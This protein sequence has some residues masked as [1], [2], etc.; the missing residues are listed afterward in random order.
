MDATR[1]H[2]VEAIFQEIVTQPPEGRAALLEERCGSDMDLRDLV[3]QLLDNDS[4]GMGDF[5]QRPAIAFAESGLDMPVPNRVGSYRVVRQLGQGGMGV[6]YEAEQESPRREVALKLIR[7]GLTSPSSLSRF[8]FEAEIL[9][10]LQHPGIARVFEAGVTDVDTDVGSAPSQ[11]FF[12]MELVRGQP[13]GAH[14]AARSLGIRDRLGLVAEICDAVQYAH[15]KG[16]IHRDLKPGNIIVDETGPKVLDFGVARATNPDLPSATLQT[17]VGQLVGTIAYMSPEQLEATAKEADASSDVYALGVVAYELLTGRLP[18]NVAEQPLP[19]AIRMISEQEA[20]PAGA[21]CEELAGDVEAILGKAMDKSPQRRYASAA[22]FAA[23]IRRYLRNEPVTARAPSA[24][25]LMQRFARRNRGLVAGMAAT[26]LALVIGLSLALYAWGIASRERDEKGKALTAEQE[27]RAEA[28]AVTLFFADMLASADP[29]NE[30]RDARVIDLLDSAA[31][32]VDEEFDDQPIVAATLRHVIGSTYRGLGLYDQ[33]EPH[34]RFALDTRMQELGP[35]A[36]PTLES[37]QELGVL[38]NHWGR[39]SESQTLLEGAMD[40]YMATVGEEHE[41]AIANLHERALLYRRQGRLNLGAELSHRALELRKR[42][43]G[44]EHPETL[45]AM[46]NL[47]VMYKRMGH[48]DEAQ[49]LYENTLSIRRR[50]L[51]EEHPRTLTSMNNLAHLYRVQNRH[52]ESAALHAET[53]ETRRRVLG[54]EHPHTLMSMDNRAML[55][56]DLDRLDEAEPLYEE[57]LALKRSTLGEEHPESL[58]SMNNLAVLYYEQ[59][60]LTESESL[61]RETLHMRRRI[62]GDR[63]NHT[64]TSMTNLAKTLTAMEEYEEAELLHDDALEF[65]REALGEDHPDVIRGLKFLAELKALQ[66]DYE[67][68]AALYYDS[69]AAYQQRFPKVNRITSLHTALAE[70]LRKLGRNDEADRLL[71]PAS[72]KPAA[73]D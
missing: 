15:R 49:E 34:V 73:P 71:E 9:G 21:V 54:N 28:E 67:A 18:F 58:V 51:G 11:P 31:Q 52:E 38:Y 45:S 64:A 16:V 17:G 39:Y 2:R 26:L 37:M 53:L 56:V 63:H 8:R 24:M 5:M 40:G 23:D 55:L 44:D 69:L 36:L 29:E 70:V 50:I 3:T 10:Q 32:S 46:N 30:G 14:A 33:A 6:V 25:Y 35:Q 13:L 60:R 42:Q 41:N 43:L 68:A 59:D 20:K 12:A 72:V 27:A 19:Q 4:C 47:G 22:E 61:Q 7:G 65:R 62:L 48:Y 1:L 66:D 57:A